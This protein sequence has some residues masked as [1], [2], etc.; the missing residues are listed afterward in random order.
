MFMVTASG[1]ILARFSLSFRSR[2]FSLVT[3][4]VYLI[5]PSF[6]LLVSFLCCSPFL[7]LPLL[8]SLLPQPFIMVGK[9]GCPVDPSSSKSLKKKQRRD[10]ANAK[11]RIDLEMARRYSGISANTKPSD[12]RVS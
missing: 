8:H 9:D 5:R 10:R 12:S 1:R 2:G 3:T 6:L 11:K 4:G 7:F